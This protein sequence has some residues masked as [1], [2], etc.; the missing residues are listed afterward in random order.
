ME[1]DSEKRKVKRKKCPIASSRKI[2][3]SRPRALLVSMQN[4]SILNSKYISEQ[5]RVRKRRKRRFQSSWSIPIY[6]TTECVG[7]SRCGARSG[8]RED[9]MVFKS[10]HVEQL[11]K[12][13]GK[14]VLLVL[15]KIGEYPC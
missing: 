2:Q 10:E 13:A 9:P 11:A 12:D 15:N 1:D 3:T 5:E 4:S 8:R 7:E 6:P 14:N